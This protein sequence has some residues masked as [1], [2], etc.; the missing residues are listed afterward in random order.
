MGGAQLTMPH[1]FNFS[2]V[3]RS[4]CAVAASRLLK[5]PDQCRCVAVCAH[6]FWS[7]KVSSGEDNHYEVRILLYMIK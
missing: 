4:K 7:G 1:P 5:K 3:S 2:F 6:L